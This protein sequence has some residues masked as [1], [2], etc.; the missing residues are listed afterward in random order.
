MAKTTQPSKNGND[1]QLKRKPWNKLSQH[2]RRRAQKKMDRRAEAHEAL[3]EEVGDPD[4]A[5]REARR[6]TRATRKE[7]KR[8]SREKQAADDKMAA[9]RHTEA[10]FWAAYHEVIDACKPTKQELLAV[11]SD[12]PD[13]QRVIKETVKAHRSWVQAVM[14]AYVYS[15]VPLDCS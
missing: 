8:E 15:G 5:L 2:Q 14:K 4:E 13:A 10:T 6:R 3:E 7:R 9:E 12:R 1:G 11:A